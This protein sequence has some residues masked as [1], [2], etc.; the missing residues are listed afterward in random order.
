MGQLSEGR[1]GWPWKAGEELVFSGVANSELKMWLCRGGICLWWKL[2][3]STATIRARL[4]TF[5]I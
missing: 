3:Q 1:A 5:D 2:M 4:S